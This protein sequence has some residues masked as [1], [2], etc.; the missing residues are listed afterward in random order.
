LTLNQM[1]DDRA[2][3]N[4]RAEY[5]HHFNHLGPHTAG[6]LRRALRPVHLTA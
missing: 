1:H 4:K 5:A 3:S 6:K 2:Y